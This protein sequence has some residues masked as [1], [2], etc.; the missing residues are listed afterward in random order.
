MLLL[1]SDEEDSK[2]HAQGKAVGFLGKAK[3]KGH[4]QLDVFE[5][6]SRSCRCHRKTCFNQFSGCEKLVI[7]K[8]SALA[9]LD[10]E[11]RAPS[12]LMAA[13]IFKDEHVYYWV[14]VATC[15][16]H[17]ILCQ[18]A[19]YLAERPTWTSLTASQDFN[20]LIGNSH[21]HTWFMG[22]IH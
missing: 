17:K 1:A 9:S 6:V 11:D 3:L 5:L 14:L 4:E 15:A 12:Q 8:R 10:P 13:F 19:V 18:I 2:C 22:C 21:R 20:L 16:V 7:A